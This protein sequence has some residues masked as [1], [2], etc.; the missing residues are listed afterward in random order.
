MAARMNVA[1]YRETH[2]LTQQQLADKISVHI[3]TVKRWEAGDAEPSPMA[4]KHMKQLHAQPQTDSE[5]S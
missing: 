2:G 3:R 5:A 1:A 4:I